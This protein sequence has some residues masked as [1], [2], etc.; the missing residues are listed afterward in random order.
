MADPTS[1]DTLARA[2]RELHRTL[3]ERARRD[4]ERTHITII[5]PGE[6]LQLLTTHEDFAWLRELS[7]LMADIDIVRDAESDV[8]DA[9]TA[10]VRPAVEHLFAT[11]GDLSGVF[12]Q[13]YWPYVH[14]DPHVAMAHAGVKQ[15]LNGW[16]GGEDTTSSSERRRELGEQARALGRGGRQA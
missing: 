9:M 5:N 13:R 4:Y 6:L 14:D 1:F 10:A 2:L 12:A 11:P 3:M 7:E 16:P 15:A 8:V